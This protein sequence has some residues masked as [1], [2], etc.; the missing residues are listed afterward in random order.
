MA[1]EAALL[2]AAAAVFAASLTG[3]LSR[4]LVANAV[5]PDRPNGRSSHRKVASRAGGV[6][7]AAGFFASAALF[8]ALDFARGAAAGYAALLGCGLAAF[9]FGTFDDFR[10][11][12]AR[13]KL[14]AQIVIAAAFVA[15]FGAVETIPLPF[16]GA[17]DLGVAAF[18]LTAFWIVAFMNAYNF[19]DGVNGIAGVCA[20][21]VLAA[22]AVAASAVGGAAIGAPAVLLACAIFG[23]LPLNLPNGRIFMGDGGSQ[24]IGFMI[25]A[26]AVMLCNTPGGASPMFTPLAFMPFLFDVFFT[27][28]HRLRRKR[29]LL[30]AHNEHVYQLLARLGR[31]HQSVAAIYLLATIVSTTVAM[32]ANSLDPRWQ[33]LPA[34][35]LIAALTPMALAVYRRADKAGLLPAEIKP[36]P[37]PAPE[38]TRAFPAAAE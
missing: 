9:A 35:L 1:T 16:V 33:F 24:F 15:L 38:A 29:N 31:P 19:M 3:V 21:Y 13:L 4:W 37:R 11:I 23:F 34:L 27:L 36:K 12:G 32:L 10:P 8:W 25:A 20:I 5:A 22:I 26:F 18:P 7:I 2:I 28:A 17:V 30:E 6:A 14:A